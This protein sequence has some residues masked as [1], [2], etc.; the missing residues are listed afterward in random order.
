MFECSVEV[1]R[2]S[3]EGG[4]SNRL[5]AQEVLIEKPPIAQGLPARYLGRL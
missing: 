4:R 1:V 5:C 2:Y 3:L